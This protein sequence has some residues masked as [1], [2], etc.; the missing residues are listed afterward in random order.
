MNNFS[1]FAIQQKVLDHFR[2]SLLNN[3]MAHAYL[4][5][6]P[7]GTGKDAFALELARALNCKDDQNKPCYICPSCQKISHFNHPDVHFIFPIKKDLPPDKVGELLKLKAANP[8]AILDSG[9]Q[10]V[11]RIDQIR[12]LKNEAKYTPHEAEK[13]V[14]IVSDADHM[15]KEAANSFLKI[16]EEPPEQLIILLTTSNLNAIPITIRSRCHVIYF[17]VL[18]FD[19]ARLVVSEFT[20]VD[21]SVEEQIL[22]NENNLKKIFSALT[23]PPGEN[24]QLIYDYIRAIAKDDVF[25]ITQLVDQM[26]A[27]RDRKF[28]LE[29]LNLLILWFKDVIHLLTLNDESIIVNRNLKENIINFARL[30]SES[31]FEL[32]ID[33]IN[34]A[35]NNIQRNANG[36]IVLTVLGF[37]IKE[38]LIKTE[39]KNAV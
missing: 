6:G 9:G 16:L 20:Q 22:L 13:K 8:F 27:S 37:T 33:L 17:P 2:N 11:T 19:Q 18:D 35:F 38:N 24:N 28:L 23:H 32:I 39:L 21:K 30:Y 26:T 12:Q 4:F 36:K 1:K 5:Y 15:N 31:N 7:E 29:L 3:R 14:Y 25:S 10:F 34:R